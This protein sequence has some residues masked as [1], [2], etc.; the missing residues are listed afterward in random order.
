MQY[1][2]FVIKL[3]AANKYI[4]TSVNKIY[5]YI[6]KYKFS[7]YESFSLAVVAQQLLYPLHSFLPIYGQLKL[8]DGCGFRNAVQFVQHSLQQHCLVFEQHFMSAQHLKKF[9]VSG[10]EQNQFSIR[11]KI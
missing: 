1:Y 10:N 6:W 2:I 7:T 11:S 5:S 4:K 8:C 3:K 9:T